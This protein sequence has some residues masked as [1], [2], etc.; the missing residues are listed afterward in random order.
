M[1]EL[2]KKEITNVKGKIGLLGGGPNMRNKKEP[3]LV[4]PD[5]RVSNVDRNSLFLLSVYVTNIKQIF[6]IMI[7]FPRH[8]LCVT[9]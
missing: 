9:H 4:F 8:H 1:D 7:T 6:F 5:F 3:K 2:L